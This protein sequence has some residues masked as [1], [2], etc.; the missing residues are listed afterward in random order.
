MYVGMYVCRVRKVCNRSSR[1]DV[2]W[3]FCS[4]SLLSLSLSLSLSV[5]G[6]RSTY[7]STHISWL[8]SYFFSSDQSSAWIQF[9]SDVCLLSS[10]ERE[11]ERAQTTHLSVCPSVSHFLFSPFLRFAVSVCIL[12]IIVVVTNLLIG[13]IWLQSPRSAAAVDVSSSSSDNSTFVPAVAWKKFV[14]CPPEK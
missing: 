1:I 8:S 13:R 11:R 2:C 14:C 5:V 3:F 10:W 7:P 4:L 9:F 12:T 6:V